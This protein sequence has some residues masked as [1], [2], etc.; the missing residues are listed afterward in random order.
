[1]RFL[2]ELQA[3]E[4]DEGGL[5]RLHCELSRAGAS[6]EW[7]KGMLQL[8]P[9]TKYQMVQEGVVVE[10]LVH[11]VE[12]EDSGYYTCDTGH[13][14]STA[15]LSVRGELSLVSASPKPLR[16]CGEEWGCLAQHL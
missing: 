10:L 7:R 9:C 5:A 2:Q 8:F 11:G 6:V 14:Q 3:Q 1:M 12:Q 13:A 16:P 4:V 15:R